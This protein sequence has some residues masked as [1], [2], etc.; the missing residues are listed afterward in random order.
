MAAN[1]ASVFRALLS[2]M[3]VQTFSRIEH[4]VG[5][6]DITQASSETDL[7]VHI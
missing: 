7:E 2:G 6:V 5:S 1:I 3:R 4:A